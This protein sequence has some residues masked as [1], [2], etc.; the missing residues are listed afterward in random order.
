VGYIV[1]RQALTT[2]KLF[3]II[4]DGRWHQ[5]DELSNQTKIEKTKLAQFL[6]F[7][8]AQGII[9]CEEKTGRIKVKPEWQNLLPTQT[10]PPVPQKENPPKPKFQSNLN[11]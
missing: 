9:T 5:I 11:G 7:L 4:I 1:Q 2:E 3:T 10:E 8:S 6:Q